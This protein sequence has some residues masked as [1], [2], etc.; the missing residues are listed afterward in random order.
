MELRALPPTATPPPPPKRE[1]EHFNHEI[2]ENARK[3][4][5]HDSEI[6]LTQAEG[7]DCD[8]HCRKTG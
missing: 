6:P 3:N 5:L 2:H 7:V 1:Q 8:C 4:P